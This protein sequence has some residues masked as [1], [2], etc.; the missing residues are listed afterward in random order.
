MPYC[1]QIT[2][3]NLKPINLNLGERASHSNGPVKVKKYRNNFLSTI[4]VTSSGQ[5]R[6]IIYNY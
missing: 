6:H 4:L 2:N 5:M 3:F 1:T